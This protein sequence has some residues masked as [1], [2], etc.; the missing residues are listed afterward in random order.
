MAR[1]QKNNAD[2][3]SHDSSM[4]NDMK[5][6]AL[7]R[8]YGMEWYGLY[9]M[10]LEIIAGSDYFEYSIEETDY[11]AWEM[12]AGDV[13]IEPEQL[14]EIIKYMITLWLIHYEWWKIY[15]DWLKKRLQPVVEKRD[16]I[17]EFR[18]PQ[19]RSETEVIDDIM[20][21]KPPESG[22][23][24][25]Q[26][27]V[28]TPQMP[29]SK[30]K[31]KKVKETKENTDTADSDESEDDVFFEKEFWELYPNKKN[32]KDA[33]RKFFS[34]NKKDRADAIAGLVRYAKYWIDEKTEIRYIVAP[35]S[36]INK[37][38]WEDELPSPRST[39]DKIAIQK[40]EKDLEAQKNRE[41]EEASRKANWLR[42][43]YK[44]LPDESKKAIIQEA[45]TELEKSWVTKAQGFYELS[46]SSAIMRI[47]TQKYLKA[48]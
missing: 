16:K 44:N 29:Q 25:T 1:P 34:L 38:K 12:F 3:F 22:V 32:K 39:V 18:N 4:R 20:S 13:D 10:L 33:K 17:R 45:E 8:K 46:R 24:A 31:E 9:C 6:K 41:T 40:T 27:I 15:S 23:C 7:R 37:R 35:D 43:Q 30:V 21:Q 19:K 42:E 5:I 48:Q 28:C 36:W 26:T 2:Y 11:I 14:R 47:F